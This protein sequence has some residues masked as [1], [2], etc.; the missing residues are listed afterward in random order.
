MTNKY[1][2]ELR[3]AGVDVESALDRFMGSESM[4]DKFLLKFVQDPTFRQLEESLLGNDIP[5]AFLQA[6]TMKGMC[7]NLELHS[8]L[9]IL[10]P[11]TEQLRGGNMEKAPEQLDRL[12]R[13]YHHVCGIIQENH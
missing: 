7:A 5:N 13:L 11:M 1:K 6:H 8:L 2:Q 10:V 9:D 4:Y 12:N 3:E